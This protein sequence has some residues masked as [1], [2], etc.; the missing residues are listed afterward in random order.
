MKIVVGTRVMLLAYSLFI[1]VEDCHSEEKFIDE[2]QLDSS[3]CGNGVDDNS[4]YGD[5]ASAPDR[6]FDCIYKRP[7]DSGDVD[8]EE[9]KR[10]LDQ[11]KNTNIAKKKRLKLRLVVFLGNYPYNSAIIFSLLIVIFVHPSSSI[12]TDVALPK[13][14]VFRMLPRRGIFVL[15]T[16][17]LRKEI[18]A[19]QS[20]VK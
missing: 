4:A 3:V 17:L 5:E 2:F 15:R 9:K 7:I 20:L 14:M 18:L 19:M 8:K 16:H 1:W 11:A 13:K 10:Q 12:P 6:S